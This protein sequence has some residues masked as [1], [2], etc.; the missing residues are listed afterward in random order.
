MTAVAWSLVGSAWVAHLNGVEVC[1]LKPKDI[2][3]WTAC[4]VGDRTWPPPT[5]MPKAMPQ[6]TKFF[7]DLADA[8]KSVEVALEETQK[9]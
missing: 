7:M 5:H 1:N 4:W 9:S 6:S 2:G 3:G 8:K